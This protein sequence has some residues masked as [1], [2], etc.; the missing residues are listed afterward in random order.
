MLIVIAWALGI[1]I[2]VVLKVI[3]TKSCRKRFY[4]AFYRANPGSA[5]LSTLALECWYLGLGGGVLIARFTQFVCAAAFWVGR[6]DV[7]FLSEDVHI[8]GYAFDYVPTNFVKD[9]LTHEAHRLVLLY[10]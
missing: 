6:T 8:G 7:P 3:I 4:T 10:H 1:T 2:T 5:N 9:L